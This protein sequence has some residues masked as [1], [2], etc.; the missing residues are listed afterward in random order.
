MAKAAVQGRY[1]RVGSV[2]LPV[3]ERPDGAREWTTEEP[4]RP[5]LPREGNRASG[6]IR[7][8]HGAVADPDPAREGKRQRVAVNMHTDALETEYAYKR[9]SEEAY[10]AGRVYQAVIEISRGRRVGERGFELGDRSGSP[11]SREWALLA[12]LQNAQD[13]VELLAETRSAIGAWGELVL[14]GVLGEGLTFT[15]MAAK[16]GRKGERARAEIARAFREGLEVLAK[17]WEKR[18]AP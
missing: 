1:E 8:K 16:M 7:V 13:A 15:Q 2:A 11:Q 17:E 6:K 5:A 4:Q 9:I 10:R 14:T 18:G 12:R 3:R